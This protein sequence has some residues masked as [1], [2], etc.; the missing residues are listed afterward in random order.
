MAGVMC[1][2]FEA[3]DEFSGQAGITHGCYHEI[4]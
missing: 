2:F 1:S 3:V 4:V